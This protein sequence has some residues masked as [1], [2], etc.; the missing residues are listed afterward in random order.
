MKVLHYADVAFTC[1]TAV[2]FTRFTHLTLNTIKDTNPIQYLHLPEFSLHITFGWN[3][4][5]RVSKSLWET[6]LLSNIVYETYQILVLKKKKKK[7]CMIMI[8]PQCHVQMKTNYMYRYFITVLLALWYV[9][10][11]IYIHSRTTLSVLNMI[12]IQ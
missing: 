8:R 12:V 3:L 5:L 10:S 6:N 7:Y 2:W 9:S 4:I 1:K 11:L